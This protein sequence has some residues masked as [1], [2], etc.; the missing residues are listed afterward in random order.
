[1]TGLNYKEVKLSGQDFAAGVIDNDGKPFVMQKG[2]SDGLFRR[3]TIEECE[4]LKK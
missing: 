2:K 3:N 4:A 1:L